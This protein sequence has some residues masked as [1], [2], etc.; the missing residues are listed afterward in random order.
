MTVT[1]VTVLIHNVTAQKTNN[2]R[3][4]TTGVRLLGRLSEF[5]ADHLHNREHKDTR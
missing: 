5:S 1:Q 2:K 4:T 3:I